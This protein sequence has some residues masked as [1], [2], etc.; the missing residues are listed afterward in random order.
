MWRTPELY[1][2]MC[3]Q[4][5]VWAKAASTRRSIVPLKGTSTL[6]KAAPLRGFSIMHARRL[7]QFMVQGVYGWVETEEERAAGIGPLTIHAMMAVLGDKI[8]YPE[9]VEYATEAYGHYCKHDFLKKDF[10]RSGAALKEYD[11]DEEILKH[12]RKTFHSMRV[13]H[14]VLSWLESPKSTRYPT[15]YGRI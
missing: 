5:A 9:L 10:R 6:R 12:Y 14:K 3:D 7:S 11:G 2:E 8:L 1:K 13:K 15:R 4:Q